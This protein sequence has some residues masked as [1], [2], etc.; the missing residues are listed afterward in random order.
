MATARREFEATLKALKRAK[1]PIATRNTR[2]RAAA[3]KYKRFIED[4]DNGYSVNTIAMYL[5]TGNTLTRDILGA[6]ARLVTLPILL[7]NREVKEQMIEATWQK[8]KAQL[9]DRP[10]RTTYDKYMGMIQALSES[11]DYYDLAA[12]CIAAT[13]RRPVEVVKLGSFDVMTP[14]DAQYNDRDEKGL[15]RDHFCWFNGQAKQRDHNELKG[16]AYL[17]PVLGVT[18]QR[19]VEMIDRVRE[20][21]D[22]SDK[23]NSEASTAVNTRINN[24]FKAALGDGITCRSIRGIGVYIAYRLYANPRVSEVWWSANA[25][26]HAEG[27]LSTFSAT[28]GRNFVADVTKRVLPPVLPEPSAGRPAQLRPSG[29]TDCRAQDRTE[30]GQDRVARLSRSCGQK[31]RASFCQRSTGK[32]GTSGTS[33]KQHECGNP[34]ASAGK[35]ITALS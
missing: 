24:V 19:L 8:N 29:R 33:S 16:V 31:P 1:L 30:G 5:S 32:A 23:T 9:R 18:P 27:D 13:M 10:V 26:G 11:D 2:L 6:D 34:S 4:E 12:C 14:A 25:L 21:K 28:Y 22:L 15:T 3:E 17:I 7:V 35:R 20:M